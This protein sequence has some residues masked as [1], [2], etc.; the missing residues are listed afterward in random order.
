MTICENI[1]NVLIVD[2]FH[3]LTAQFLK[4]GLLYY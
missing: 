2:R 1:E 4:Y 3:G